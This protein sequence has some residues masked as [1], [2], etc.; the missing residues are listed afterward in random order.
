L[1]HIIIAIIGTGKLTQGIVD[2]ALKQP[3]IPDVVPNAYLALEEKIKLIRE[4]LYCARKNQAGEIE[5]TSPPVI[6]SISQYTRNLVN[7]SLSGS[8]LD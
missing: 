2:V 6:T 1:E 4:R 3:Y 8:K 5:F 7:A